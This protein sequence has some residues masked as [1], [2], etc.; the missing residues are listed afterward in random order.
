M[1]KETCIEWL[2]R[3]KRPIICADNE[4]SDKCWT[5]RGSF[6][7]RDLLNGSFAEREQE[8]IAHSREETTR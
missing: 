8:Y 7:E 6:A 1:R 5:L 3:E 4:R 2:E